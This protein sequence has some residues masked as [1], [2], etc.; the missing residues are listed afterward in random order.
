M[1]NPATPLRRLLA[2]A[3]LLVVALCAF[4]GEPDTYNYRQG[5]EALQAEDYAKA[6]DYL[7]K[8]IQAN[9]KNGYAYRMLAVIE[10]NEGNFEQATGYAKRALSL[11]PK[12]ERDLIARTYI[13]QAGIGMATE[14]VETAF[15]SLARAVDAK[16]S[17]QVLF[18]IADVYERLELIEM[19]DKV[20]TQALAADPGDPQALYNLAH[21]RYMQDRYD[22]AVSLYDRAIATDSTHSEYFINRACVYYLMNKYEAAADDMF[23]AMD[24]GDFN[25]SLQLMSRL[26]DDKQGNAYITAELRRR[27]DT[28]TDGRWTYYL[29]QVR[30]YSDA[31][32]REVIDLLQKANSFEPSVSVLNDIAEIY[33]ENGL[34]PQAVE[35]LDQSLAIDRDS[36]GGDNQGTIYSEYGQIYFK[37]GDYTKATD[38]FS[39]A[40]EAEGD[41]GDHYDWRGIVH[42]YAG[43]YAEAA[44]DLNEAENLNNI[45]ITGLVMRGYALHML[46][47]TVEAD[48]S[49]RKAVERDSTGTPSYGTII[50]QHFLGI[51][52]RAKESAARCLEDS[53]MADGRFLNAAKLYNLLGD[54]AM[55]V[56]RT[57]QYLADGD[58]ALAYRLFF[59]RHDPFLSGI[60][61]DPEVAA[62]LADAERRMNA[63]AATLTDK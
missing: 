49:F 21:I 24:L 18:Y 58:D 48:A 61:D 15:N 34:T 57:K 10:A 30:R 45:S 11:L 25:Q 33:A 22:E 51:D 60:A 31:P 44:D 3:L 8:E 47:N 35:T 4:A 52:E 32:P 5:K 41:N 19:A 23:R 6:R 38:Y 13:L 7:L 9:K 26:T 1:K 62:A 50:S 39:R 53:T 20:L 46:G 42:A 2:T 28:D 63:I 37:S 56:H 17:K 59:V 16:P 40:I 27:A 29:A 36:T 43:R 54:H 12:D 55:A 14:D